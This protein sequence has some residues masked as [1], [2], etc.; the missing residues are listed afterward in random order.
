MPTQHQQSAS[1]ALD[2]V[3]FWTPPLFCI[4]VASLKDYDVCHSFCSPS[5]YFS[6]QIINFDLVH[7]F[8]LFV[9]LSSVLMLFLAALIY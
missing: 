1:P 7:A 5:V 2:D 6:P 9:F 4:Y 3:P 8:I